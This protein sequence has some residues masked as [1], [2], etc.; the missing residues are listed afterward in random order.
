MTRAEASGGCGF[1]LQRRGLAPV[2]RCTIL[3]IGD[4][5]GNDIGWGL[6]RH[7]AATSG[8][9]LV[10][11]DRSATGLA[12]SSFYDWPAELPADLHQYHPQ[13]VLICLGGNDEQGMEVGGSA[14]Q[15]P[16]PAWK[17]AYLA[18]VRKLVSE[19]TAS[20]AYV[21]WIGL[22][23]MQEPYYSQGVQVL[24]AL[25]RQAV[26]SEP[27]ATFVSTWSLLSNPDGAFQSEAVINGTPG[28]LR[29]SDGIHYSFTG[30]DVIATYVL[31]DLASVYHVRLTPTDPAVITSWR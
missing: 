11:L 8:L 6:V 29:Q 14:V 13:L 19:A 1:S 22:P 31:R 16:T 21:L 4:S 20:G 27:N 9:N 2:G 12:D 28:S 24:N 3:E 5:L 10:Q 17:S 30:E 26:I 7:V 25:Y 23:I 15:F 18:R